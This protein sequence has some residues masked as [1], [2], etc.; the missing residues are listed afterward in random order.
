MDEMTEHVTLTQ[1]SIVSDSDLIDGFLSDCQLRRLSS[2]T[3]EGYRSSLRITS[4]VL[5]K[6]GL[7]I[8]HLDKTSLMEILK[9]LVNQGYVYNTFLQYFAA[10]SGF[11]DYLIWEEIAQTNQ[12]TPFRKRYLKQYK[13]KRTIRKLIS[14]EEM[15]AL[16][17]SILDPRDKAILTILAKTGIRRGELINLNLED[18]DWSDQSIQLKPHPKRSNCTVFFDNET[19]VILRRWMKARQYY[20]VKSDCDALFVNERG[21][22]LRRHGVEHAVKKHAVRLGIHDPESKKVEDHFSPHCCRHWFTTQL[23][24]NGMRR[25]LIKELRGDSRNEAV[26]LYD[27]IDRI[28]LKRAYLA[29][30]PVLGIE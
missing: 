21:S 17:N 12:V 9:Y 23:R 25:E 14:I 5:G 15:A 16:I 3:I 29:A 24:R 30:I 26:D 22:R 18:V 8:R 27:H 4:R 11:S 1:D 10:L 13:N 28:E 20:G 7:S 6:Q 19:A 2:E